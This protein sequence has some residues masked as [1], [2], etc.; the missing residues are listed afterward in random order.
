M[1]PER[2]QPKLTKVCSEIETVWSSA[3]AANLALAAEAAP[4]SPFVRV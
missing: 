1:I 3:P 2:V 4:P